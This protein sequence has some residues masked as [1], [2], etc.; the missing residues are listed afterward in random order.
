MMHKIRCLSYELLA[1]TISCGGSF[2][3][4]LFLAHLGKTCYNT[5]R[6]G[7]REIY[8]TLLYEFFTPQICKTEQ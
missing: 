8:V 2:A 4:A 7:V 3:A 1:A 6:G 5:Q